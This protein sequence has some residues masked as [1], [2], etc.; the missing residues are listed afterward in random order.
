MIVQLRT[1]CGCT[2]LICVARGKAG[3]VRVPLK[4]RLPFDAFNFDNAAEYALEVRYREFQYSGEC[5][6][7][8]PEIP[9][10]EEV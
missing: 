4:T 8:L 10:F 1:K 6:E 5:V 2:K 3:G 9:V 7:G